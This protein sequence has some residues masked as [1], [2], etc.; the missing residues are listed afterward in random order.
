MQ[1]EKEGILESIQ[2]ANAEL[3]HEQ[4]HIKGMKSIVVALGVQAGRVC[5]GHVGYSRLYY[6]CDN[7]L[8][9][10][11]IDHSV[12]QLAV[13]SGEIKEDK[14]CFHKDRNK[15]LRALG[16]SETV[17]SVIMEFGELKKGRHIFLMCTGG[18]WEYVTDEEMLHCVR[19]GTVER[20]CEKL[21]KMEKEYMQ[22]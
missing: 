1:T 9:F 17:K 2:M 6:F 7:R 13:L 12:T 3:F 18:F 14:M 20:I 4:N 15:L 19:K 5:Y 11:S 21:E 16:A 22:K 10:R 8:I